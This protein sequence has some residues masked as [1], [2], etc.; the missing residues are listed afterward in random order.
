VRFDSGVEFLH[1]IR[2]AAILA[3]NGVRP[4]LVQLLREGADED[5]RNALKAFVTFETFAAES[6]GTAAGRRGAGWQHIV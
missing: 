2:L 4:G 3:A 6:T 5:D 1:L